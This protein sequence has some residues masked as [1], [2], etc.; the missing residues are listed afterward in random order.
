MFE[1]KI[2]SIHI[3]GGVIQLL[4]KTESAMLILRLTPEVARQLSAALADAALR[5]DGD[6][7]A[8]A[9]GSEGPR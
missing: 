8:A 6:N 7:E 4:V 5:L 2:V 9:G 3:Q 1:A